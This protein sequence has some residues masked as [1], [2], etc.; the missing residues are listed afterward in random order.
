MLEEGRFLDVLAREII[1][2][3]T[4]FPGRYDAQIN[5][6]LRYLWSGAW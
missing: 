4:Q 3:Q 1:D 2:V 5:A 6:M